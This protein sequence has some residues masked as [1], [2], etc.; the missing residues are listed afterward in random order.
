MRK[1]L[2][3]TD[4]SENA[5][6]ALKYAC[7]FFKY[8]ITEFFI[9]H[10]YQDDIY[11]EDN[12]VTRQNLAE[13]TKSVSQKSKAQLE[14]LVAN[15]KNFSSNP[16]HSYTIISSN[17]ILLDEADIIVKNENIDLI[18]MGTKGASNN[19]K[20]IFGSHTL[21]VL[22]YVEC[23]VLVIPE[24]Y[25]YIQPKHVL[26]PTNYLIPYK[27]RELQLL[28]DMLF[29]FKA[30][31]D[32]LYVS[33]SYKLLLRQEDNRAFILE[34]LAKVK[35][36]FHTVNTTQITGAIKTYI[37][38]NKIDLLVMVNSRHSHLEHILFKSRL[39]KLSLNISIPFLALQNINRD[40]L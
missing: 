17:N 12:L 11:A 3:P 24:N 10:A 22:K 28:S 31:V 13:I 19:K 32:I 18:L 7:E 21:Q 27:R 25:K 37:T 34:T 29:P 33:K 30:K 6:N 20:L 2:I 4:F 16:K 9:M 1:I 14:T 38:E 8:D 15:I 40:N 23:P 26:F 5:M 35:T 36:G 39:D